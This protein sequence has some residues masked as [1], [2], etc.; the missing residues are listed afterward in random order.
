MAAQLTGETEH[1]SE[2]E[3]AA[4]LDRGLSLAERDRVEDHLAS[5]PDCRAQLMEAR[6]ILAHVRRPK[7]SV[8]IGSIAAAAAAVLIFLVRPATHPAE[9]LAPANVLRGSVEATRLKAYGPTGET[10]A[11]ALRFVWSAAPGVATYRLTVTRGDG[12]TVW[13]QG[14]TDTSL[15]LPDSVALRPHQRYFWVAD[16]LLGDG[17]TRSTGLREFDPVP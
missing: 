5:C 3:A 17:G 12:A 7:R 4:Y 16:A 13:S 2:A 6:R 14:S 8:L 10:P 9:Q 15:A 1:L 11:R